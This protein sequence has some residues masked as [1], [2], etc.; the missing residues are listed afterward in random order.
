MDPT[1]RNREVVEEYTD[2]F[3]RVA[4]AVYSARRQFLESNFTGYVEDTYYFVPDDNYFCWPA[5][6]DGEFHGYT[7]LLT[8][9]DRALDPLES[10]GFEYVGVGVS[11]AAY[12]LPGPEA[13]DLVVKIGRCGMGEKYGTGR[14]NNLIECRISNWEPSLPVLPCLYC[15][16]RGKYAVYPAAEPVSES[17]VGAAE[18]TELESEIGTHIPRIS[19]AELSDS[20]NLCR[21]DG[22]LYTLDY[23]LFDDVTYPLGV[24]DHIDSRRVIE[25]VDTLRA[26]GEK[27]DIAAVGQMVTPDVDYSRF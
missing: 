11:R 16:P 5:Q 24:P 21:W 19:E 23:C 4:D 13:E 26:S 3:E 8:A 6:T 17:E 22:D 9:E 1:M 12:R 25:E 15:D 20:A 27:R 2:L 18:R 10:A 7:D 14:I